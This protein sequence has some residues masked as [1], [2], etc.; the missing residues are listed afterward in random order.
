MPINKEIKTA[1][2]PIESEMR[3]P[4]NIRLNKSL[5]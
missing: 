3:I 5:P 4:I 2:K 1:T